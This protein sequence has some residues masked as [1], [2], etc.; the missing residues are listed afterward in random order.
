MAIPRLRTLLMVSLPA[1]FV[2]SSGCTP[3]ISKRGYLPDPVAEA[4]I[5]VGKDTKETI[6]K[7]LGDPTTKSNFSGRSWFYISSVQQRVAFFPPTI[8]DR[9]ILAIRFNKEDKVTSLSH[10]GL[11]DGHVVAFDTSKTPTPGRELTFLQQL[12]NA[13]PGVPLGPG[14]GGGIDQ[15]NPGGGH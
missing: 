14:G 10:Y 13:T 6:E 12:L 7:K 1:V 3:V 11:R 4:S 2:L 5:V 15:R 9:D 8:L